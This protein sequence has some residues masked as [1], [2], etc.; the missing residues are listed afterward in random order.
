V[1]INSRVTR[2]VKTSS[3]NQPVAFRQVEFT[4]GGPTSERFYANATREVILS[5]GAV[6]TPFLLQISGIG[7]KQEL[8]RLGIQPIVNLPS[9]GKNATDHPVAVVTWLV[10]ST[11][12]F[13]ELARN[14][15]L[16]NE[17]LALWN[18]SH[19]GLFGINGASQLRDGSVCR[20]TPL[21][22]NVFRI[23]LQVPNLLILS[24]HFR[25]V[26]LVPQE[27]V[28]ASG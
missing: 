8:T 24:W 27:M 12:T 25:T 14:A 11:D 18:A 7:D 3:G 15:T 16:F 9:V 1:L 20:T 5:A 28:S 22:L 26:G 10:N 19:R 21:F 2:L 4:Q 17:H 23:P 13:D 6:N